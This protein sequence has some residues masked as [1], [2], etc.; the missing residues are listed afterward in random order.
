MPRVKSMYPDVPPWPGANY[1]DIVMNRPELREYP[2]YTLHIDGITGERR[3]L[4]EY[5]ERVADG[6][7]ALGTEIEAGGLGL[8]A[9]DGHF[10][11]ILS[12]NC[13]DYPVIVFSLLK[14]AT[15]MALIP[16]LLTPGEVVALLKLSKVTHLFVG[17]NLLK[18][19]RSAA[20]EIGL[21][22][23]KIFI[24]GGQVPGKTS[25]GDLIEVVRTKK[26]ARVHSR[27]VKEDT[28]AYMVFSSGTSGLPKGVLA[29]H[30]NIYV[31][32]AQISATSLA[33][34]RIYTPPPP[35]TPEKIPVT[36]CVLPTY[37]VMGLHTFVMR[38]LLAPGTVVILPKWIVDRVADVIPKYTVTQM[39]M[40]PAMAHHL[41][42]HPKLMNVD[43][44]G[45]V[46]MNS[47]AAYLPPEL[48][49]RLASRAPN[50]LDFGE[51]YGMSES[52]V[53]IAVLAFP[54]VFPHAERVSG[55][56]GVLLPSMEARIL[57]DD[58]SEADFDEPGELL[59]RGGNVVLGY[60]DND[61]ANRETFLEGGWLRTGDRFKIDKQGRFFFVDRIKDTLKI[62]GT[63]VSPSEI[64][65][66]LLQHSGGLIDDVAVAGV[67]LPSSRFTDELSP[68][69]WVVLSAKGRQRGQD[70]V[71]QEL[72]GWVR[73]RLS[74][75][76]WLRGGFQVVV[77]IPKLPTGKVLRRKLQEE[78]LR[79][80]KLKESDVRA[81][82]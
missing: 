72:E 67:P 5:I 48:R 49:D 10:V 44:S 63:Q 68:H 41:M 27:P 30:K 15:P 18:L 28:V 36:L 19:A 60:K 29:S 6:A 74:K 1:H 17:P 8:R 22:E 3:R 71:F 77:E 47:G 31:M 73:A 37:H 69:A 9:E 53:A 32:M 33:M 25:F 42:T 39:P 38:L 45:M 64:E 34:A 7:T 11:G 46:K 58:G 24:I 56:T 13:L 55:M 61:K 52:T 21:P 54:G 12:E 78:Y 57:R 23:D 14:I 82:L 62:S 81:K 40:V 51:G 2:N 4:R 65:S 26:V 59:V 50:L 20:R 43:L 35:D 16:S 80:A 66:T 75:P 70:A 79:A 76:K